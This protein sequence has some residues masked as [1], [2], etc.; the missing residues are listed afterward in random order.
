MPID[1]LLTG[2]E[3]EL[4]HE[5]RALFDAAHDLAVELELVPGDAEALDAMRRQLDELFL[6]MVV[7]EFNAGK[8]TFLNALLG[9]EILETG[10]LPT[11][12]QVHLLRHGPV[13]SVHEAEPGLLIHELPAALLEALNVVDTPGTNSM[14]REEQVLT[15]RFVPRADLVFFLTSLVR[16]YAASEH[17]FLQL[18]RSWGKSVLF[19]I[20]QV[21]LASGPDH[22]ERVRRYVQQQV[23]QNLGE[24]RPVYAISAREVV[25]ERELSDQNEYPQLET[26]VT[27]TLRERE[28]VRIKLRAPLDSLRTVLA[29]QE[30]AL[31]ERLRLVQGDR[32]ALAGILAEVDAYENRMLDEVSRYQAQITNVLWQLE[33]RGDRFFDELVRI[34][35]V[36][37]LRNKDIVE[38]RFRIEVIADA[39]QRIEE[40]VQALIDWLV[41]QNLVMWERADDTLD[42]RRQALREAAA[43]NRWM[44]PEFVYNREEIFGNLAQPVRQRL[45][46]FDARQE[47]DTVVASVNDAIARTFSV[48]ALVIGLGAV[49]TAAFT[50]LSIDV[51]GTIGAT[52]LAVAALFI[53]PHRRGRLKRELSAK[54]ATLKEELA[55]T[56]EA[57]FREQ[58]RAYTEQL[59]AAFTPE[60]RATEAQE[61]RLQDLMAR[62]QEIRERC[63]TLLTQVDV[64]IVAAPSPPPANEATP[65]AD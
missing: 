4:V 43:R 22:V 12:R 53:L 26:Y 38:N 51:T 25:E 24:P 13:K 10:E 1:P 55:E 62:V 30:E 65:D 33:R 6:I 3:R 52:V 35:N 45:E 21:D 5:Q 48:Q 54:V 41:R 20:N 63:A 23:E 37:R 2:P 47:A 14:Q 61:S 19:V 15:E 44:S 59:R 50:T 27:Q 42:K 46:S 49:L 17:E 8:S 18:I 57:R 34:A 58:L 16:P 32:S 28:R 64:A 40:E 9:S 56:L 60:L 11:T 36:M 29:R 31:A 39:P 7:G